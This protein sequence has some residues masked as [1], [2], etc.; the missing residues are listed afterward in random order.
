MRT[1]VIGDI[2]GEY[3]ALLQCLQRANFDYNTDTLISLGDVVDRGMDSY[4]VVEELLKVK[5]LIA[6]KGNHDIIFQN[7]IDTGKH[8]FHW[9]HGAAETKY[10]YILKGRDI[11]DVNT[12]VPFTKLDI[13]DTHI[14]FFHSQLDYYIDAKNRMF[15]HGGFDR[16]YPVSEQDVDTFS[17]DREL[18]NK[19]LTCTKDQKLNTVD[20][21]D[22]IYIGHTPTIHWRGKDNQPIATPMH[23]GGIWNMDTGACFTGGKLSLMNV[24]TKE[25]FQSDIKI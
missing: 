10:S 17:W 13:P 5:N 12:N 16:D 14:K 11:N 6:V 22:E 18:W 20:C 25:L 24:D 15:V 21:F 8:M 7:W 1:F 2:H 9:L 19:A 23:S 4:L 3:Q